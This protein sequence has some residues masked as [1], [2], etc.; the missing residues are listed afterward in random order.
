[1]RQGVSSSISFALIIVDL[2]VVTREF[3][4]LADLSEAQTLQIY[5]PA[6]V[7]MVD[8]YEDIILKAL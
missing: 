3:L 8:K 5:K 6:E 1:M 7:I 4:G 2:E